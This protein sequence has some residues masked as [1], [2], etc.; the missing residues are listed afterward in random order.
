MFDSYN[1]TP[2]EVRAAFL[3]RIADGLNAIA[4]E[5]GTASSA[6]NRLAGGSA[7]RR[8]RHGHFLP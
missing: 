3:E 8:N 6:G 4:P 1:N 5:L 7:R 2:V